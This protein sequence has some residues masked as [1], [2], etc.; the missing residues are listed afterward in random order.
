M[1]RSAQLVLAGTVAVAIPAYGHHSD[2]GYNRDSLVVFEAEV[3]RYIFRNPHVT[4]MVETEDASG[5]T[6]EWEIETGSTP[7][8]QRSGWSRDL[9]EVGDTVIIRAHPERTG[10]RRAILNTMEIADG[11]L[12]MQI[13]E[14]AQATVAA[15]NLNGVWKGITS[16]SLGR[17][18]RQAAL[19]PAGQS[20]RDSYNPIEEDP[21][22][23]C[24][25]NPPPFHVSSGNYLTGIEMLD[26]R[27]IIRSEFFDA[28]RTVWMDGRGHPETA[29]PTV[30]GHSIGHWEGDTLVVDTIHLAEH[31]DGNGGGV[32]SSRE[33][34]VIERFSL[35]EDGTRALVDVYI[36]DP[37]Y[38]EEP[39]SGH[40]EM[41]FVPHLQLYRYDCVVVE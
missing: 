11:S 40:T 13:E 41:M 26:D 38:L 1:K 16:T 30:Q 23:Q 3:T 6:V 12:W 20:A 39:F 25:P 5:Q 14:D 29:E 2:A 21:N 28:L 32:P 24:I 9:V 8:M 17:Q 4:L 22:N 35:S 36:E 19:T 15:E 33:R 7:I 34:H 37:V 31:R 27:I 10:R 18:V